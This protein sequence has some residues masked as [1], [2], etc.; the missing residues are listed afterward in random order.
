MS[1]KNFGVMFAFLALFAGVASADPFRDKKIDESD[2]SPF[3]FVICSTNSET[4]DD[5]CLSFD[6]I[7]DLDL[8]DESDSLP[9]VGAWGNG[10]R[11]VV[12]SR[13]D[14]SES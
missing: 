9:G 11:G 3:V 6:H 2:L 13:T 7:G 14:N 12:K 8:L 5:E 4:L 10:G 1:I